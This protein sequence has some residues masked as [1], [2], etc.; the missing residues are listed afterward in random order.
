MV[1]YSGNPSGRSEDGSS[2]AVQAGTKGHRV[3]IQTEGFSSAGEIAAKMAGELQE[4]GV[5]AHLFK[6]T[7]VVLMAPDGFAYGEDDSTL[8]TTNGLFNF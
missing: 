5:W 6:D 7:L 2:A 4:R 8:L 3:E 1:T